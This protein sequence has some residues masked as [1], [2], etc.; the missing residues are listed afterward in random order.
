MICLL[1]IVMRSS[2]SVLKIVVARWI[3]STCPLTPWMVM[4]SPITK[5]RDRMITRPAP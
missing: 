1:G 5:G 2:S 4:V 3:S